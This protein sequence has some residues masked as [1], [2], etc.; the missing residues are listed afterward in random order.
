M[1]VSLLRVI[2]VACT[3]VK[4]SIGCPIYDINVLKVMSHVFRM[5]EQVKAQLV[6]HFC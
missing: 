6:T 2:D 3:I 5:H 4:E 1:C